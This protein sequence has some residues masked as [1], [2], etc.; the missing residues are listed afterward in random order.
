[1]RILQICNKPPLPKIDGGCVAISNISE[2]LIKHP[3][4]KLKILTVE[5]EKHPFILENYPKNFIKNSNIE[6]VFVDT[7]V[8]F[9]DAFSSF[10]TSD[11]Y[12]VIRFFSPSFDKRLAEILE[13]NS[14]DI[15]HIESI[16]GTPYLHTIRRLSKARVVLRSHNVEHKLWEEKASETKNPFKKIY[17]KYLHKKLKTYEFGVINDIDA[18]AAIS[19]VDKEY[20]E[21]ITDKPV[22]YIPLGIEVKT[23]LGSRLH[24]PLKLFHIGAMDW[25]HNQEGIDWFLLDIWPSI[26]KKFPEVELHLAGKSITTDYHLPH[27]NVFCHGEVES[28]QK[29]IQKHDVLIIP[30][31]TASGLRIKTIE[32]MAQHKLVISTPIGIKGIAAKHKE[33][34]LEFKASD[35]FAKAIELILNDRNQVAAIEKNAFQMVRKEYDNTSV[36]NNLISF[37]KTLLQAK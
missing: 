25:L 1:M 29:F 19:P 7:H 32:A 22:S 18:L 21:G 16:F 30:L 5:T 13:E 15:I 28:A 2:G 35:D 27:I 24:K 11:S 8:N 34:F 10:I 36:I 17:L 20:L 3:D 4:V 6:A 37:Y 26:H 33:H 31:K 23:S 9:I 12:N 14:F